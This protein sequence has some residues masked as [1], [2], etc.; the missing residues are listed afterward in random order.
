[1]KLW[2]DASARSARRP[3]AYSILYLTLLFTAMVVD[4]QLIL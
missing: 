2:R 3:F 1:V 4:R